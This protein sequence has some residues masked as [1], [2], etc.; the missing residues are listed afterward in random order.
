MPKPYPG[1]FLRGV[2]GIG[3]VVQHLESGGIE[4]LETPTGFSKHVGVVQ[5]VIDEK[6]GAVSV[7]AVEDPGPAGR[8]HVRRVFDVGVSAV[9]AAPDRMGDMC[10]EGHHETV[11]RGNVTH[12]DKIPVRKSA[13]GVT[14][15]V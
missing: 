11:G 3:D 7:T 2:D 8:L 14:W 12:A 13:V 1:I 4:S 10:H 9:R 5:E 15:T 6:V